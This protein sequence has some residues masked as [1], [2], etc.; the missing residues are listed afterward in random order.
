MRPW[1]APDPKA[2]RPKGDVCMWIQ[3]QSFMQA[4]VMD[5]Q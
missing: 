3:Q 2:H 4:A 1:E 5:R